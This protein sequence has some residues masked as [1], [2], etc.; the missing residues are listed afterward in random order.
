MISTRQVPLGLFPARLVIAAQGVKVGRAVFD[1]H[2]LGV[3]HVGL[4]LVHKGVGLVAD[5]VVARSPRPQLPAHGRAA[6]EE[7][8]RA[9][10]GFF[11]LAVGLG[12]R[13]DDEKPL[14]AVLAGLWQKDA[15]AFGQAAVVVDVAS[16]GGGR[17]DDR[18]RRRGAHAHHQIIGGGH[19]RFSPEDR[20]PRIAVAGADG[21][22]GRVRRKGVV[23]EGQKPARSA[24]FLIDMV[25]VEIA[26]VGEQGPDAAE[27]GVAHEFGE[28]FPRAV[29]VARHVVDRVARP[30]RNPVD[31]PEIDTRI[32]EGVGDSGGI[33]RAHAAALEDEGGIGY[34]GLGAFVHGPGFLRFRC[35]LHCSQP[36]HQARFG[37]KQ[38]RGTVTQ[39]LPAFSLPYGRRRVRARR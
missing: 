28:G 4:A 13:A 33:A 31:V 5:S 14:E 34:I 39:R 35:A 17:H 19:I 9:R 37:G 10:F 36:D 30:G 29:G 27:I 12:T 7:G 21:H 2:V 1:P 38:A 22:L 24:D 16:N 8:Q 26:L 6:P 18:Q 20:P 3:D 25:G 23:I 32:Q 11:G 15:V